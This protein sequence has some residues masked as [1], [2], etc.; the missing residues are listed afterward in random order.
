[1]EFERLNLSI[2]Q[3]A[4]GYISHN[5]IFSMLLLLFNTNK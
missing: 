1:M 5:N 4:V 3:K 2:R